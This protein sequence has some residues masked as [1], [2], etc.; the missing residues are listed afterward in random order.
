LAGD[1]APNTRE[2]EV[3]TRFHQ[4][5]DEWMPSLDFKAA[6]RDVEL[7]Y[8]VG[9]AIANSREWPRWK[10]G[11]DFKATREESDALRR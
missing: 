9:K 10:P 11:T 1:K 5:S 7:Y 3:G 2:P 6:A 8:R 4:P